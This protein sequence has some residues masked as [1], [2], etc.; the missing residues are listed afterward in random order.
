MSC[1]NRSRTAVLWKKTRNRQTVDTLLPVVGEFA[2]ILSVKGNSGELRYSLNSCILESHCRLM[3]H[4]TL[5]ALLVLAFG[6]DRHSSSAEIHPNIVVTFVDDQENHDFDCCEAT[7]VKSSTIDAGKAPPQPRADG[8]T[9]ILQSTLASLDE[10]LDVTY[11][12]YGDRTL[13]M[14]IYRPKKARGQLPALVCIHGGGWANGSRVNHGKIAQALAARGYVAATISYR[15]SGEASFPAAI[16]D[17][18]AAVRFLRANAKEYGIDAEHIGAIGLSAGGHLTALLATSG[19]AR[20]LEGDGGN[21]D[22]SSSIQAAVPMG[23][24]TDFMSARTKEI[25]AIE[26]R[27]KIWRQFLGGSQE[28]RPATYRVASPLHHLAEN[29]PPCWFITGE[30]DDPSTHADDFRKRMEELKIPSGLTVIKDAPH[31]FVGKQVW[32][33]EMVNVADAFFQRTFQKK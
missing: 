5:I 18:K 7:E 2:G 27:G 17:C 16:N 9:R 30:T 29:D 10:K 19:G 24:Q 13:E 12:R 20:E 15:L 32:F 6:F 4:A 8:R 14:D 3:K 33:D 28:D 22:F 11:A 21:A 31:P 23:A 25:S 1:G 26:K